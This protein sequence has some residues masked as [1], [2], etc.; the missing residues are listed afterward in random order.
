MD[1]KC[2][3]DK[4]YLQTHVLQQN[5]KHVSIFFHHHLHL[6]SPIKVVPSVNHVT[7]MIF[8][9]MLKGVN[10]LKSRIILIL[11]GDAAMQWQPISKWLHFQ[12]DGNE[13]WGCHATVQLGKPSKCLQSHALH[14][15]NKTFTCVA[16]AELHS[17]IVYAAPLLQHGDVGVFEKSRWPPNSKQALLCASPGKKWMVIYFFHSSPL[18]PTKLSAE[19]NY[20]QHLTTELINYVLLELKMWRII[21]MNINA[22]TDD[23]NPFHHF[24]GFLVVLRDDLHELIPWCTVLKISRGKMDYA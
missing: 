4:E 19:H 10:H 16:P 9:R 1:V 24:Q 20:V 8:W 12:S 2:R 3:T 21:G 5:L 6:T 11:E 18:P 22:F 23:T 14:C 15:S 13:L 17:Y 7:S